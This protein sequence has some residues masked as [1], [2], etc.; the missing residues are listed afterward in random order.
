MIPALLLC[1]VCATADPMV[2]AP[3]NERAFA[4]RLRATLDARMGGASASDPD[5]TSVDVVDRRLEGTLAWAPASTLLLSLAVPVLDRTI[6]ANGARLDRASLGDVEA[7]AQIEAWADRYAS[8]R[9]RLVLFVGTK[10]PTA[11]LEADASGAL[12]PSVLQPGCSS[13]VPLLG[14]AY[15]ASRAPWSWMA[16]GTILL[17]F[18]V[19]DAAPHAGDSLRASVV[20]SWQPLRWLGARGGVAGRLDGGGLLADGEPDPSSGGLIGY[21]SADALF[22]PSGD[23][24]L[25]L[26]GMVPVVQSWRGEHH[27]EPILSAS[28]AYDF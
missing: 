28:A 1:A 20:G 19:R 10:V 21:V 15:T 18:V 4:G 8:V 23:L 13:I 25:S 24:V 16:S 2:D 26:G 5:G 27:E 22:S 17:P 9:R 7:R 6:A 3:G 14:V 11:P 12:L